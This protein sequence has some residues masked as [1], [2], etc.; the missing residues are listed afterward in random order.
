MAAQT[1]PA[2]T[3]LRGRQDA[4]PSEA[5]TAPQPTRGQGNCFERNH[6]SHRLAGLCTISRRTLAHGV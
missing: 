5:H 4:V 1:T 2:V 6:H 3:G